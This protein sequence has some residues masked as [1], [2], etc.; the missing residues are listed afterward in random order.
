M[1][2][3]FGARH[4][5]H[6]QTQCLYGILHVYNGQYVAKAFFADWDAAVRRFLFAKEIYIV[7]LMYVRSAEQYFTI[8]RLSTQ[9]K[10][11]FAAFIAP[12]TQ[13][14]MK[15]KLDKLAVDF[16]NL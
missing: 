3:V 16:I 12:V 8:G 4:A 10:M 11:N 1:W 7:F 9:M 5:T 6:K 2:K 13:A 15:E 14:T